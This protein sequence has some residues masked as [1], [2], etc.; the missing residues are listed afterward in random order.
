M[1]CKVISSTK[2]LLARPVF[3]RVAE[4]TEHKLVYAAEPPGDASEVRAL[5]SRVA[6]LESALQ[7]EV[8]RAR[9]AGRAE[10]ES[11]GRER[12]QADLTPVLDRLTRGISELATLRA[13]I[14]TESEKDLVKLALCVA[15]RVVRRELSVD[16]DAVQGLVRAALEKV[17]SKDL[18]RLRVHPE[19]QNPIRRHVEAAGLPG[20]EIVPDP[21]LLPGDVIVETRLGD[22]DA[23]V[24]SQLNEIERGFADRLNR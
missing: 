2:T 6:E 8:Q 4:H 17:Q 7:K 21:S 23:S 19:F 22:L 10:G 20:M 5:R 18:R 1:A 12:A 13:R 24:E 14:R 3:A 16:P 9:D 11:A 15:R